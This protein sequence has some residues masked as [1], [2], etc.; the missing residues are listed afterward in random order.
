M[1]LIAASAQMEYTAAKVR[2]S[3]TG[4]VACVGAGPRA[5]PGRDPTNYRV[6]PAGQARE[7]PLRTFRKRAKLTEYYATRGQ[8]A[9]V[10]V[11]NEPFNAEAPLSA[12]REKITP[13]ELF[14]VRNNFA[15]PEIPPDDWRLRVEGAVE[16]PV[17][18]TLNE[19]KALPQRRVTTTMEC[20]GNGHRFAPLQQASR[21]ASAR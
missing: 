19:L 2:H 13:S 15:V 14:Y 9:L 20:A 5:C 8:E 1:G 7:L 21:G 16:Q 17:A 12:L 18:L 10:T 6:G 4:K 3:K 11:K